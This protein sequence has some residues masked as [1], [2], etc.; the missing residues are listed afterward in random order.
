MTVQ[1]AS[2]VMS[3]VM[4]VKAQQKKREDSDGTNPDAAVS[5]GRASIPA[6]IAVPAN[7][8]DAPN[9]LPSSLASVW[10]SGASVMACNLDLDALVQRCR[11]ECCSGGAN[12][13]EM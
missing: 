4:N 9:T 7:N 13:P 5:A 3:D 11:D 2:S 6:P 1:L 10:S 12:N 8:S